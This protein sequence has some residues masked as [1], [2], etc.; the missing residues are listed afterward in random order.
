MAKTL[1]DQLAAL[2]FG[3]DVPDSKFPRRSLS[4]GIKHGLEEAGL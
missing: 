2:L 1:I 4:K 3:A